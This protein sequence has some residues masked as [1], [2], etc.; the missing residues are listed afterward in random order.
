[1]SVAH[2]QR[3]FSFAFSENLRYCAN[4]LLNDHIQND[5]NVP[6]YM[7]TQQYSVENTREY[8]VD[9]WYR[10]V[11]GMTATTL[12]GEVYHPATKYHVFELSDTEYKCLRNQ[13]KLLSSI[14][15]RLNPL[16]P[17]TYFFR[18]S[19]RS[20]KDALEEKIPIE[21][22]DSHE[23]KLKKKR[24]QLDALKI[25]SVRSIV[26]LLKKSRR[27]REDLE[28]YQ[29]DSVSLIFQDWRPSTGPEYRCFIKDRW[30]C[31]ICLYKPEYYSPR[32]SVPVKRIEHFVAQLLER[33]PLDRFVVDMFV[34]QTKVHF[35]EINP[36][37]P[38]VDTFS[39]DYDQLEMTSTLLVTL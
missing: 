29:E 9:K 19:L 25:S 37:K 23:V 7:T 33:V 34:D 26:P 21:E 17:G 6:H 36:F 38:F 16:F 35:I 11:A 2:T 4:S 20:P 31:G 32:T 15:E 14:R 10:C 27:V 8:T 1:M 24:K 39:L 18:L 30:L 28:M 13:G 3:P 12:E 5:A 22:N